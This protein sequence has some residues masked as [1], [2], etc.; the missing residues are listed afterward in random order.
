MSAT[1]VG[2][3]KPLEVV[4][5]LEMLG[6]ELLS[7]R[8]KGSHMAVRMPGVARPVIVQDREFT[9]SRLKNIARQAGI[10]WKDFKEVLAGKKPG[11][12]QGTSS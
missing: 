10:E 9:P 2:T 1:K 6:G 3:K 7:R 11:G 5:A 12:T 4:R 8:G